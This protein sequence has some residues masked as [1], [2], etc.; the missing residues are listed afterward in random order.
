[1]G[2]GE[3]CD[4]LNGDLDRYPPPRRNRKDE[5]PLRQTW[6]RS[7]IQAMLAAIPDL[8]P[9]LKPAGPQELADL[10]EAFD[11]TAVYDKAGRTLELGATVMPELVPDSEK[12]RR[13]RAPSGISSIAGAG[14]GRLSATAYRITEVRELP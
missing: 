4:K 3:I 1:M 6:S 13:S 5:M 11:V 14:F 2:L 7:Q 9:S 10:L 8:R 12:P